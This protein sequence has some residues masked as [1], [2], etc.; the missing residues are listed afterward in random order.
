MSKAYINSLKRPQF[1]QFFTT[2]FF[3]RKN[4]FQALSAH[5]PECT[6]TCNLAC[7]LFASDTQCKCYLPSD[8]FSVFVVP[9]VFDDANYVYCC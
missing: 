9:P 4:A 1:W 3:R 8:P 2:H 7:F 6:I 5:F